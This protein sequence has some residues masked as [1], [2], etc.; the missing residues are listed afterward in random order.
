MSKT[1]VV[2]H[3]ASPP[4]R[5]KK[6][7]SSKIWIKNLKKERVKEGKARVQGASWALR[8]TL[9]QKT[10]WPVQRKY[11]APCAGIRLRDGAGDG[12]KSACVMS[13]RKR[14]LKQKELAQLTHRR[15]ATLPR[16]R[17]SASTTCCMRLFSFAHIECFFCFWR[18]IIFAMVLPWSKADFAS[19][20]T[21]SWHDLPLFERHIPGR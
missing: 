8:R 16:T 21:H 19:H 11:R 15:L 7:C 20:N 18:L 5:R 6:I 9:P 1:Y 3:T 12:D 17:T 4:D 10:W 14:I 2:S 13:R